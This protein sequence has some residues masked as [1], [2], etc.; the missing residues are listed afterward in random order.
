MATL[1]E[2]NTLINDGTLNEKVR[3]A[4]IKAAVAVKFEATDTPNHA[5]RLK[6][7][8]AAL[9]DPIGTATR[10]A[11]YVVAANAAETLAT[12]AALS[13]TLIQDHTNASVDIFAD[14]T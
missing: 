1:A 5:N 6:W 9:N 11:R 7:A 3:G 14:G 8:K 13:D 12:I 2:L 4:V 10:T